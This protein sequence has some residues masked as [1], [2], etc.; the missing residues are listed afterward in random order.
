MDGLE[1]RRSS[2]FLSGEAP[3][4]M[5][6]LEGR[7]SPSGGGVRAKGCC[8]TQRKTQGRKD[9]PGRNGEMLGKKNLAA[10]LSF[11]LLMILE[12]TL[13]NHYNFL[14]NTEQHV[15]KIIQ[16][17]YI[18]RHDKA[19]P[20]TKAAGKKNLLRWK[21]RPQINLEYNEYAMRTEKDGRNR[22]LVDQNTFLRVVPEVHIHQK[23][24]QR[25][26]LKIVALPENI[27]TT[28]RNFLQNTNNP[29][30]PCFLTS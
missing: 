7:S 28:S 11:L 24:S 16:H 29:C 3:G 1:G 10:R 8:Q 9:L 5:D 27:G 30:W 4:N 19:R 18:F 6:G 20:G 14:R 26:T 15:S 23:F 12:K 13:Q 2:S 17:L 21:R 25:A 22:T